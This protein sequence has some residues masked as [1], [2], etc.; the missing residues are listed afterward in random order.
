MLIYRVYPHL[1]GADPAEPGGPMH[2]H[3]PQGW[4][5]ADNLDL[6]DAWYFAHAPE[7]A[8]GEV[9]GNLASWSDGMFILPALVGARRVLGVYEVN[10]NATRVLDLDDASTL[11]SRGL[12]PTQVVQRNRSVTQQWSR[13]IYLKRT[14]AGERCWDGIRWWSFQR[15]HW[16]VLVLWVDAERP[17]GHRFV[18]HEELTL[19]HPAV[20]DAA[21]SLAKPV[22]GQR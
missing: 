6:Y 5:R 20:Q 14:A 4:G 11:A 21:R 22:D 8:V 17:A 16:A 3:K 12:R 19:E 18:K 10:E 1:E 9:F 13:Q 7:G 15:P 2:L